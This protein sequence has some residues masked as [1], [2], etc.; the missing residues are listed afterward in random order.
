MPV[1]AQLWKGTEKKLDCL[2]YQECWERSK[3]LVGKAR[4]Q[5]AEIAWRGAVALM[6]GNLMPYAKH[7]TKIDEQSIQKEIDWKLRKSRDAIGEMHIRGNHSLAAL[8]FVLLGCPISILLSRKDPL[9]TFFLC[10]APIVVLYYPSVILTFNVFKE[11]I[12]DA[13]FIWG[14]A[15][16][17]A[18]SAVMFISAVAAIRRL[19][20]S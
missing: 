2:T 10:F 14:Q 16:M 9:Q 19:V 20:R 4:A 11:G 6:N 5:E 3:E 1:P 7:L 8:A 18:P 12:D 15:M 17:W 13:S